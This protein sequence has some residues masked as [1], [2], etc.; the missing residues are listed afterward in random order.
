MTHPPNLYSMQ[1]SAPLWQQAGTCGQSGVGKTCYI[2]PGQ[3]DAW[4]KQSSTCRSGLQIVPHRHQK[5]TSVDSNFPTGSEDAPSVC[6]L[7]GRNS[8][9]SFAL[10]QIGQVCS[11]VSSPILTLAVSRF[12]ARRAGRTPCDG[13]GK[14]GSPL[15]GCGSTPLWQQA[16]TERRGQN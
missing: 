12:C 9:I 6:T 15:P 5:R 7:T 2:L 10:L 14:V 11:T 4:H 3:T 16:V 8:R 1:L 13:T